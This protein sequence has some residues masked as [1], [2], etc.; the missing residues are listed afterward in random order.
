M[1]KNSFCMFQVQLHCGT[2]WSLPGWFRGSQRRCGNGYGADQTS[3]RESKNQKAHTSSYRSCCSSSPSIIRISDETSRRH[4]KVLTTQALTQNSMMILH[5]FSNNSLVEDTLPFS[6]CC[7]QS[8]LGMTLPTR[9]WRAS[10][11]RLESM[12]AAIRAPIFPRDATKTYFQMELY[13]W[14][15]WVNNNSNNNNSV[16]IEGGQ[17]SILVLILC[18]IGILALGSNSILQGTL[19]RDFIVGKANCD[20]MKL[21]NQRGL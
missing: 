16:F 6:L 15:I 11:I 9:H 18:W 20:S 5:L 17:I 14:H 7:W 13:Y 19:N 1:T 4:K 3:W 10:N 8:P 12:H 2:F 21:I